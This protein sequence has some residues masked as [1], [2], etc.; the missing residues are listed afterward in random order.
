MNKSFSG[1][2]TMVIGVLEVSMSLLVAEHMTAPVSA[3]A[4]SG[5][6]YPVHKNIMTTLFWA[7][8]EADEDNENIPNLASAWDE[9]WVNHFGGADKPRK[10][11]G[12][13]PS[14]FTP[15]ENPFYF[16]LPYNDFD[17]NGNRKKDVDALVPWAAR[18]GMKRG[19]SVLKNRWIKITKN[20]KV[21]YAQWEDVGPFKEND[22]AYV[23]GGAKPKSAANNHAGLDVSPAVHD[24]LGLSGM[25]TV[26]WQF[27]DANQVPDGPWKD[28]PTTSQVNW[29]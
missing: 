23:F 2:R 25:D 1:G 24:I 4:S 16:A 21:A 7:G 5:T 20:G 3:V 15:R 10:R 6:G 18:D 8:E 26:D 9:E 11:S 29:K 14:G 13:L 17:E 28:M 22:S 19:E 12:Y 27:V